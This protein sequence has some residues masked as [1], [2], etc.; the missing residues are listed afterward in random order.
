MTKRNLTNVTMKVVIKLFLRLVIY[1][2]NFIS[3]T[4]VLTSIQVSN[5]IRHQRIHT[6]E[7]P[8]N[9]EN[10]GKQFASGSNLKQ[11]LQIHDKQVSLLMTH[12]FQDSRNQFQCIFNVYDFH[13][14]HSII[15]RC[16]KRY[17]YPS[18]LKKHYLVSHK[19]EYEK[20][21]EE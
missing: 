12:A 16:D 19:E 2:F 15:F 1:P 10:C 6:G 4:I 18:S 13:F 5:L 3:K 11:H 14:F 7:K 17:L 21:L 8:Y 20:Y 9:C